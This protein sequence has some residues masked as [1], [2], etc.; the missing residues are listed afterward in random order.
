M[1]SCICRSTPVNTTWPP[2]CCAGGGRRHLPIVAPVV[3]GGTLCTVLAL[4][5]IAAAE[6]SPATLAGTMALLLAASFVEAFPVPIE[7]VPVGGTSLAVGKGEPFSQTR[8]R[9]E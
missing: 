3:F 1:S 9:F 2:P 7:N 5:A 4:S 6:P 8:C